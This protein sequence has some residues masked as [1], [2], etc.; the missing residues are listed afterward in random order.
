MGYFPFFIDIKEKKCLIVGGGNVALRK[1]EKLLPYEPKI[2]IVAP[3]I[4]TP[5]SEM[6]IEINRRE[7]RNGDLND[8]FMCIAA[9]N[10]PLVNHHIYKLC[11]E[12]GIPVNCVD[13]PKYCEFIFPSLISRGDISIGI[14]TS[15]SAPAF[16]RYLRGRIEE[17]LDEQT[18]SAGVFSKRIRND[19]NSR[20]DND[21]ERAKA[22]ATLIELY[23]SSGNEPDEETIYELIERIKQEHGK[24][25]KDRHSGKQT[26]TRTD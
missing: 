2:K 11:T 5:L 15:G 17:I 25:N 8:V 3:E 18:L 26:R 14:S 23:L 16:A 10:S 22:A 7:F 1:V 20:L 6:D 21:T 12:R 24:K 13:D 19:I 9:S 4:C